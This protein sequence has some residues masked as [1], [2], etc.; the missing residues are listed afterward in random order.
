[1]LL[2]FVAL[3]AR[4]DREAPDMDQLEHIKDLCCRMEDI[5]CEA[6]LPRFDRVRLSTGAAGDDELWF[7]WE[8]RR[9]CIVVELTAGPEQLAAALSRAT[10]GDAVLN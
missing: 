1:V 3:V 9:L 4:F 7:L 6:G 8:E 10:A 5:A 2:Q